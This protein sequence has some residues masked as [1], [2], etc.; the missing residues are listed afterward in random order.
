V[1]REQGDPGE[2]RL[3]MRW[4]RGEGQMIYGAQVAEI[5]KIRDT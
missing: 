3:E 2:M 5:Y 1:I 4:L